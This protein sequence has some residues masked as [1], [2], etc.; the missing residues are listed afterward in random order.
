MVTLGIDLLPAVGKPMIPFGRG[1]KNSERQHHKREAQLL[2]AGLHHLSYRFFP[3]FD[4]FLKIP[5]RVQV[6][7]HTDRILDAGTLRA[8]EECLLVGE[9]FDDAR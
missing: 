6:H 8:F 5:T 7:Q 1:E 9:T 2:A 4:R 3:D